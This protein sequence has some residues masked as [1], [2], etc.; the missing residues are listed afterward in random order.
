VSEHLAKLFSKCLEAGVCP[1]HFRKSI[2]VV[3]RKERKENYQVVSAYRP[4]AL[5]NTIGKLL[6]AI[7][8]RRLSEE[9]TPARIPNGSE[10][11]Q[12][13]SDGTAIIN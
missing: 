3:L 10:E 12:V 8:A 5:L 6:E 13:N 2:T 9:H 4:I 11:R 7:L 1:A